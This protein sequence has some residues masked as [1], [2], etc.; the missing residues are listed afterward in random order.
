MVNVRDIVFDIDL[1]VNNVGVSR[2]GSFLQVPVEDWDF[3]LDT[4]LKSVFLISQAIARK[5]VSQQKKALLLIYH[6][7]LLL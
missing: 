3:V 2:L 7:K 5:M 4:N 1:L 6:H